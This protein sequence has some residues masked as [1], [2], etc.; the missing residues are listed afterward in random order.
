MRVA[1]AVIGLCLVFV[2]YLPEP[3]GVCPA[4]ELKVANA[5]GS[6][7]L[8][9]SLISISEGLRSSG[10]IENIVSSLSQSDAFGKGLDQLP[11]AVQYMIIAWSYAPHISG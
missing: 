8:Y 3:I 4:S 11:E 7:L 10:A 5:F 2:L 1:R 6:M 9:T